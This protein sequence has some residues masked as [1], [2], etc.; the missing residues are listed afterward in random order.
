MIEKGLE[1]T[2]IEKG[3]WKTVIEK[4]LERIKNN[5]CI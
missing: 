2:M 1:R 3:L 5:P 4:E